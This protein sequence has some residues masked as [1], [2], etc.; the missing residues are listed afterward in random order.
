MNKEYF[1]LQRRSNYLMM[2]CKKGYHHQ[3][4]NHQYLNHHLNHQTFHFLSF[5][6]FQVLDFPQF[7]FEFFVQNLMLEV[8]L[9]SSA[10]FAEETAFETAL[11]SNI[12]SYVK[13]QHFEEF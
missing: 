9:T 11:T 5:S 12:V 13:I 1:F 3:K 4:Y 10:E 7:L 6:P 2:F 8:V